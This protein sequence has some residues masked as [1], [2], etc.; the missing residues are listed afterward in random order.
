MVLTQLLSL[1]PPPNISRSKFMYSCHRPQHQSSGL[2]LFLEAKMC[3]L[4]P[5]TLTFPLRAEICVGCSEGP[6]QEL[7]GQGESFHLSHT[8]PPSSQLDQNYF[9]ILFLCLEE[10]SICSEGEIQC[11][12]RTPLPGYPPK[13]RAR[14]SCAHTG[15]LCPLRCTGH[16][17]DSQLVLVAAAAESEF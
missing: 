9:Y 13:A 11:D 2:Q 4:L 6:K 5:E 1:K 14:S 10:P 17:C 3:L 16:S 15:T 8:L 12:M 7:V